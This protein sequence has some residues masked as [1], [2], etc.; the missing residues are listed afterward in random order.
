MLDK[1]VL[2]QE[3][4]RAKNLS[5][6]DNHFGIVLQENQGLV[7]FCFYAHKSPLLLLFHKMH[8]VRT[9]QFASTLLCVFTAEYM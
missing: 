2:L 9:L 3:V 8:W 6:L 1:M 4:Q 5:S 7:S